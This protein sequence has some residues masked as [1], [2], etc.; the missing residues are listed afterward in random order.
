MKLIR[1][2][3]LALAACTVLAGTA[4]PM[5]AVAATTKTATSKTSKTTKKA[6]KTHHHKHHHKK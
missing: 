3:L 1:N 5:N 6:T 4:I 2:L